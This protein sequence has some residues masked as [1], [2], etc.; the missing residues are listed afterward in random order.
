MFYI[1]QTSVL[2]L[3]TL[4]IFHIFCVFL[5]F[6]RLLVFVTLYKATVCFFPSLRFI[7]LQRVSYFHLLS[8]I[9]VLQPFYF[10]QRLLQ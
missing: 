9:R 6:A 1:L 8:V 10:R 7:E 3:F 2:S 5:P 4:H